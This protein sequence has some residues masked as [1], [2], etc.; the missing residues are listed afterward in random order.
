MNTV[1]N[2]KAATYPLIAMTC[3]P[4]FLKRQTD[5]KVKTHHMKK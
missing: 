1:S 2:Y 3:N 4:E 5:F